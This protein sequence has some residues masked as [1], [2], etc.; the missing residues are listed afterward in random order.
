MANRGRQEGT[1][2]RRR[3]E[4][5]NAQQFSVAGKV[6]DSLWSLNA[7]ERHL[8]GRL[9]H[10]LPTLIGGQAGGQKVLHLLCIVKGGDYAVAG[11]G[12]RPGA[13][14]DLL[15]YRVGVEALVDA[16]AGLAQL[17]EAVAQHF[18]LLVAL[19]VVIQLIISLMM[20]DT[21]VYRSAK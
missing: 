18:N 14:E 2:L 7:A 9:S 21:R 6:P 3:V 8:F 16:E 1:H 13:V 4:L 20:P 10:K 5:G 19:V 17:G 11:V 15:Q 12:Q